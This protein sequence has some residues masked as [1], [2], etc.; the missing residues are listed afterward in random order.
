MVTVPFKIRVTDDE[1]VLEAFKDNPDDP[2]FEDTMV[3]SS[4][5]Y[6]R[7]CAKAN[8]AGQSVETFMRKFAISLTALN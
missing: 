5:Q 8:E 1:D 3:L 7:L 2:A 6:D 4:Y